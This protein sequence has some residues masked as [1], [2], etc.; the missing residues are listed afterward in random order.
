MWCAA[1]AMVREREREIICRILRTGYTPTFLKRKQ[2]GLR[3][4]K[5][6]ETSIL[7]LE[8]GI[9]PWSSREA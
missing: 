5:A 9:P 1:P 2:L 7:D 3:L 6:D 4:K 8:H